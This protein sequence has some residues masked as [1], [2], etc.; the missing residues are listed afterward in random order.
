MSFYELC[1]EARSSPDYQALGRNFNTIILR[2]VPRLSMK[3]RDWMRRFILL[4]DTL[5]F[6]HRNVIIEAEYPLKELFDVETVA[7]EEDD[8]ISGMKLQ[9]IYDE[10][11]AYHRCLSRLQEMQTSEYQ[12]QSLKASQQSESEES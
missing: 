11:F 4:I 6:Q 10:E 2:K 7:Q 5:Y 1:D 8:I 9:A 12:E 3:R